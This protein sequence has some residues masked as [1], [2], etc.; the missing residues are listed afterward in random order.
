[1][2]IKKIKKAVGMENMSLPGGTHSTETNTVEEFES[3]FRE[4]NMPLLRSLRIKE[5]MSRVK[6]NDPVLLPFK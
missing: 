5:M 1:M 4:E 2:K 3:E 6:S